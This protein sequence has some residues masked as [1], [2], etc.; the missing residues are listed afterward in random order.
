MKVAC[1]VGARP[2][3]I[4]QAPLSRALADAGHECVLIHTG[5]HYDFEMSKV[6]FDELEIPKPNYN[7]GVGSG[8]QGEQTG[9]MLAGIEKIILE[10][11]P[12]VVIV[13]GDTNSTLAGAL[14]AS[15]LGLPVAHIEAGMR[16][17]NKEMPE[18]TNRVMADHISEL[19][20]CPNK[21]AVENLR[22]EGIT[23]GVFNSGDIMLDNWDKIAEVAE[24]K[25]KVLEELGLESKGY[26]LATIHRQGNTDV[27]ENLEGIIEGMISS[28]KTIVLPAH[29][30]L[31]KM[32]GEFGL[33]E[34]IERAENIKMIKPAAYLDFVHLQKNAEKIL[35]D[36][37]GVQ[38]E[39]YYFGVPCITAREETE[40]N[41]TVG[42]GW[43]VLVGADSEKIAIALK[44]FS[45]NGEKKAI[46]GEK[47]VAQRI[48]KE[49]EENS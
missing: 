8:K 40:W 31:R 21:E 37:G 22:K 26:V 9:K 48:V 19:L 18:E 35:T 47:G 17:Y 10:E 12:S 7:L 32:L 5:Q 36:S 24:G 4:K 13:H 45:P 42:Q 46:F 43:N 6:F 14:A 39:A 44:D 34:K 29:P 41:E 2:Q 27:K 33:L 49:I 38:K 16:S 30:R 25:S 1:V 23:S 3:F 15:K 20:F 11:G 28:G